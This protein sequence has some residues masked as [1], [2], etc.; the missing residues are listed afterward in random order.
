[1]HD[2]SAGFIICSAIAIAIS[3]VGGVFGR[4]SHRQSPSDVG[5][6]CG[7]E[8][9]NGANPETIRRMANDRKVATTGGCIDCS[10]HVV[11]SSSNDQSSKIGKKHSAVEK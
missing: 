9:S 6:Y 1:M 7:W 5:G 8:N 10:R 4:Q 11:R 2:R 3:L